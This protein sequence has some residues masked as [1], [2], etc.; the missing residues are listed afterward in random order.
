M[1]PFFGIKFHTH[2]QNIRQ[3]KRNKKR[4]LAF[5]NFADEL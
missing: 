3:E 2:S 4:I 1:F 5:E